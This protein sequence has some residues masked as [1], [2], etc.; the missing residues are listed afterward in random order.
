MALLQKVTLDDVKKTVANQKSETERLANARSLNPSPVYNKPTYDVE[1]NPVTQN[2]LQ[3]KLDT[4]DV[5][6][7]NAPTGVKPSVTGDNNTFNKEVIDESFGMQ[8]AK[9]QNGKLNEW[10]NRRDEAAGK[11]TENK[12]GNVKIS[13]DILNNKNADATVRNTVLA[14]NAKNDVDK[15][16]ESKRMGEMSNLGNAILIS[17]EDRIANDKAMF[18][19][20]I[21]KNFLKGNTTSSVNPEIVY[22]YNT[23]PEA[24][25]RELGDGNFKAVEA[26]ITGN[27][28]DVVNN[29]IA[30]NIDERGQWIWGAGNQYAGGVAKALSNKEMLRNGSTFNSVSEPVKQ[31]LT[32]GDEEWLKNNLSDSAYKAVMNEY[33]RYQKAG[34]PTELSKYLGEASEVLMDRGQRQIQGA[35]DAT[36][37]D[38]IVYNKLGSFSKELVDKIENNPEGLRKE[39]GDKVFESVLKEYN[40][41]KKDDAITLSEIEN[42][43]IDVGVS[44]EQMGLDAAFTA[45]TGVNGLVAMFLRASG[46]GQYEA[47]QNMLNRARGRAAWQAMES[48]EGPV[49]IQDVK[50]TKEQ[51]D[52][53]YLY[54]T[55]VGLVEVGTE[56]IGNFSSVLSKTYGK[57]LVDS[58]SKGQMEVLTQAFANKVAKS[59]MGK[60]FAYNIA[61]II[62]SFASEAVEE[63]IAGIADPLIAKAIYDPDAKVEWSEV[64]RDGL[65][66]GL[67]GALTGGA[68][69]VM[70][71]N[72]TKPYNNKATLQ[73]LV[74]VAKS[75]YKENTPAYQFAK[76]VEANINSEKGVT[77]AEV[78]DLIEIMGKNDNIDA[79]KNL[80]RTTGIDTSKLN[81]NDEIDNQILDFAVK[82]KVQQAFDESSEIYKKNLADVTDEEKA[83]IAKNA[84]IF[85]YAI[86]S[87]KIDAGIKPYLAS[88]ITSAQHYTS[89]TEDVNTQ[90]AGKQTG[91]TF[92]YRVTESDTL[93]A[94]AQGAD[95]IT[96]HDNGTVDY[97][98]TDNFDGS[99]YPTI[100]KIVTKDAKGNF[101]NT[102]PK[103]KRI[104]ND[105]STL[106][107]EDY[108]GFDV[109]AQKEAENYWKKGRERTGLSYDVTRMNDKTYFDNYMKAVKGKEEQEAKKAQE[110]QAREEEGVTNESSS[111]PEE[112]RDN[113]G[114]QEAGGRNE[115]EGIAE[116]GIKRISDL[117]ARYRVSDKSATRLK[118]VDTL[119][120]KV[121]S[122]NL[123]EVDASEFASDIGGAEGHKVIPLDEKTSKQFAKTTKKLNDLGFEN[124]KYFVGPLYVA[125]GDTVFDVNGA[126]SDDYKTVYIRADNLDYT[127]DQIAK[128]ESYHRIL[129]MSNGMLDAMWARLDQKKANEI[130]KKYKRLYNDNGANLSDRALKEEILCDAYGLMNMFATGKGAEIFQQSIVTNMQDVLNTINEI[131]SD[132][133]NNSVEQAEPE[134]PQSAEISTA[135]TTSEETAQEEITNQNV[136]SK[137]TNVDT[138]DDDDILKDAYD[139]YASVIKS[140]GEN[141]DGKFYL[142][143]SAI[144]DTPFNSN[145][146]D[147]DERW[148]TD[149]IDILSKLS[150]M[151]QYNIELV[152]DDVDE[153]TG[154]TLPPYVI[155]N[156]S[157]N[158]YSR[159]IEEGDVNDE[160]RGKSN[161]TQ[162]RENDGRTPILLRNNSKRA[163]GIVPEGDASRVGRNAGEDITRRDGRNVG[164]SPETIRTK[165]RIVEN[166]N[167]AIGNGDLESAQKYVEEY[168]ILNGYDTFAFNGSDSIFNSFDPQKT[169]GGRGLFYFSDSDK[170]SATYTRDKSNVRRYALD[171]GDNVKLLDVDGIV[172]TKG[173]ISTIDSNILNDDS[174]SGYV[175][176][177][178][179]DIGPS[180]KNYS[181]E[182]FEPHTDYITR[183]PNAI[184]SLD[185]E[186]FDDNGNRIPLS[187]RFNNDNDDIRY[188]R[189]I[190]EE[191]GN[192]EE[193][194]RETSERGVWTGRGR[195]GTDS[196][197]AK[198]GAEG[199]DNIRKD[200]II[201]LDDDIYDTLRKK[202]KRIATIERINESQYKNYE[203]AMIEA[204]K[205]DIFGWCVDVQTE[206]GLK[207][208]GAKVFTFDD[209]NAGIA[210]EPDG[211]I[212]GF[213]RNKANRALNGVSFT[214]MS[215]AINN[216]GI[217]CD[218]F[219]KDLVDIYAQFGMVPVART[220]FDF[221]FAMAE[222]DG[223][224]EFYNKFKDD[225]NFKGDLYP[226]IYFMMYNGKPLTENL[227]GK[228]PEWSNEALEALPTMDYDAAAEYRDSLIERGS[229]GKFSRNLSD[230]QENYFSESKIRDENGNLMPMYH[231][232]AR[233]DRVGY[234]FDPNRATSGPMAF[235]T[236]DRDI[237]EGYSKGKSDTSVKYDEQYRDYYSQFRVQR[238]GK[239]YSIPELW[240]VLSGKERAA[241]TEAAKHITFDD[242]AENIVY[243]KNASRGVG[244]FDSYLL[245]ENKGNALRA[246]VQSWL[247]NGN[248]FG[249]E[250]R[251][252]Q[253][254]ELAGINDATYMDP[255]AR[256]E[257]VYEVYLNVTKP[258]NTSTDVNDDFIK[259]FTEWYSKQDASTYDR[260]SYSAD[261]WD[262]NNVSAEKFIDRVNRDIEEETSHAW[263]S[264]PDSVTDYLK[265]LGYDG[266]VDTGGKGGGT[267]HTV[268]IPFYSNQ[269]KSVDNLNPTEANDIRYSR[270]ISEPN[271]TELKLENDYLK[272]QVKNIS[273]SERLNNIKSNDVAN[274]I[275]SMYG[276][277]YS[278][279]TISS[280]VDQIKS[281]VNDR[282]SSGSDIRY[283]D[284]K[285][286][287]MD[288]ARNV[289]WNSSALTDS[290]GFKGYSKLS[291]I[292]TNTKVSLPKNVSAKIANYE[293]WKTE[294]V[295][296]I[297]IASD[298]IPVQELYARLNSTFGDEMFPKSVKT[299][300]KQA[301]RIADVMQ[302][303]R[304]IFEDLY[305]RD[306]EIMSEYCANDIIN[307]FVEQ[308]A[309]TL[310]ETALT[311]LT[312]RISRRRENAL[313]QA[314]E[315]LRS[316]PESNTS[317][318]T[319]GTH[320]EVDEEGNEKEV[321]NKRSDKSA[322]TETNRTNENAK[323]LTPLE[324]IDKISHD[325]GVNITTGHV[326]GNGILGLFMK[327][328]K[329]IRIKF[330]NQIPEATHEL[331]HALDNRYSLLKNLPDSAKKELN[332]N[333]TEQMNRAKTS[334]RMSEGVA[335]YF[336]LYLMNKDYA[337][338]TYPELTKYIMNLVDAPTKISLSQLA[339]GVNAYYVESMK[340][341]K[342]SIRSRKDGIPD[343]RTPA[344]KLKDW[345]DG[346]YNAWVDAN[347]GILKYDRDMGTNV[348]TLAT[349][350]A[351]ADARAWAT[352][353]GD[354][355]DFDGNYT[356]TGLK[357]ALLG[358]NLED[359]V[360]YKDFNEYLV[361]SHGPEF[362]R[363]TGGSVFGNPIQDNAKW[364][365][366]RKAELESQ[367]S[368]FKDAAERLYDFQKRLL[369][370]YAV[371]TGL[372]SK[373]TFDQWAKRWNKYVPFNRV[374][375]TVGGGGNNSAKAGFAN[376]TS[377]FRSAKGSTLELYDPLDNI[378]TNIVKMVNAGVRNNVMQAITKSAEALEADARFIEKIDTPV[379]GSLVH[380][381]AIK[382]RLGRNAEEA[383][384]N[385][386]ENGDDIVDVVQAEI[387]ALDDVITQFTR[388]NGKSNEVAVMIDGK[389]Q[390]WKVNDPL[391]L[392]SITSLAPKKVEGILEA[393][394]MTSRMMTANIT[395][396]NFIWSITRNAPKDLIT[397]IN[398]S[399]VK[400]PIK[401]FSAIGNAYW[402]QIKDAGDFVTDPYY[403]EYVA[404]G[405]AKT[406]AYT[407]DIN[408]TQ[409][410]IEAMRGTE[411]SVIERLGHLIKHP[412]KASGKG[413][414]EFFA[415]PWE[416]ISSTGEGIFKD[417]ETLS[418]IIEV[419]PR[420]ATYKM[421]R[422]N[423]ASPQEA[424]YESNDVTVNFRRG[425]RLAR[426]TNKVV[427]FFNANVQG[428]DKFVRYYTAAD[429]TGAGKAKAVASR[430][431]FLVATSAVMASIVAGFN[432]R[433][434]D[435]KKQYERLSNFT[436]NNYWLIPL[437]KFGVAQKGKYLA[438]P[439]ARELGIVS[440]F[441]ERCMEYYLTDNK[442]AFDDFPTYTTNNLLP[443]GLAE[444]AEAAL[445]KDVTIVDALGGML[446]NLGIIG[447][448]S[449]L[450]SNKDF[451]GRDIVSSTYQKYLPEDQWKGSTSKVAY[452]LGQ[453]F[454]FSPIQ[455]DFI[456]EQVF[457]N[458]WKPMKAVM[459]M[460]NF[461]KDK[462]LD[463]K[464]SW[465][466]DNQYSNEI[467]NWIYDYVD[468]AEK[469]KNHKETPD[470]LYNYAMANNVKSFYST[471]YS[472]TKEMDE[473]VESR[474]YRNEML[475]MLEEFRDEIEGGTFAS[476]ELEAAVNLCK[477]YSDMSMLPAVMGKEIA[478][479][480]DS[481][482]KYPLN[483][484][485]YYEYQNRYN[486]YYYQL[487][488]Q[489]FD[490]AADEDE[491]VL[492]LLK[493]KDVAKELATNDIRKSMGI[494]ESNFNEKYA[495][496]TPADAVMYRTFL[497]EAGDDGSTKGYEYADSVYKLGLGREESYNAYKNL[498][499]SANDS[500]NPW[501]SK[502]ANVSP[503]LALEYIR[504][505]ST[506][507]AKST[508][509]VEERKAILRSMNCSNRD[510]Y[511]L[512]NATDTSKTGKN[513]EWKAYK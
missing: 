104:I 209:G 282:I 408:L 454:G 326:K 380:L 471:Y 161:S 169:R 116:R 460:D 91:S 403:A 409:N 85:K 179:I 80:Y 30:R 492:T 11:V 36:K 464:N 167:K 501:S 394:A 436:R 274:T 237:A 379:R 33:N 300:Y 248:I 386:F 132:N 444:L 126:V 21:N 371:D 374:V 103:T 508:I 58:M 389:P 41:A 410:A 345:Y 35:K 378:V 4:S 489:T 190:G 253:V 349:N 270:N 180:I 225:P 506:E 484:K 346:F 321:F 269:V 198:A 301:L 244:D 497:K 238:D 226:D 297:S 105:K 280:A 211:N 397:F 171:L 423:G 330:A 288:V 472:L 281:Y 23:N 45:L 222:I 98:F 114:G 320:V 462:S 255:D 196:A 357:A 368:E 499:S 276:S 160:E 421:L 476:K 481:K 466:K 28:D 62:P 439:K 197:D 125:E 242:D 53:A 188:S 284:L 453:A 150:S 512:Y 44:I 12:V 498:Y 354:M 26:T 292:V 296:N 419:G 418:N 404:M 461:Y 259:G 414:K 475:S 416:A 433:D 390:Y 78:L 312:E 325:F 267:S 412:I 191:N 505:C 496:M 262:K 130:L 233:T 298:G 230:A 182:V 25:R 162:G 502:Y 134:S 231:G 431:T 235:F 422:D 363:E 5:G 68:S 486:A 42:L 432:L 430:L 94:E 318:Y 37:D 257:G 290:E 57:G 393:Y 181:A 96:E 437:S 289:V 251:F 159:N 406:S 334:E 392:K 367:Y 72:A 20:F 232:T 511:Y 440:S 272:E 435:D 17:Q 332:S 173:G 146:A 151:G 450:Y 369:Q 401:M 34:E 246:L 66:G 9:N 16:Y 14:Y 141:V 366:S 143:V 158:K 252:L 254:L 204:R 365:D 113:L 155:F 128:H 220:K 166:Y 377:T 92:T 329:G 201:L 200:D 176:E 221:D 123:A 443:S 335:D 149:Q 97:I 27:H 407:A 467:G 178:V 375:P 479:V 73:S 6:A 313:N 93:P 260:D 442:Y 117:R 15:G 19:K 206:Q 372:I 279:E 82:A 124:V 90:R 212:V 434:D 249:E 236:N 425:G 219:G 347:N 353:V 278:Q 250:G 75:S 64:W 302:A 22:K 400:N 54:G 2:A 70:Q 424:F 194:L 215:T 214:A 438:L 364:M 310:G 417:I 101:R 67:V 50:L 210:V 193:G 185:V 216:G 420:F 457:G 119:L 402:N 245:R 175:C 76:G 452:H 87:D 48:G 3:G 29:D 83:T 385:K 309:Q 153:D 61:K 304:D 140:E 337:Q 184:K 223:Y 88:S 316:E 285:N 195:N 243:D 217:K 446:G 77:N 138:R 111:N 18:E 100:T 199:R 157:G 383:I 1:K 38:K 122:N 59:G 263:T 136:N 413:A 131:T 474:D 311:P 317:A 95:V 482:T 384:L 174:Y 426:E 376:Q 133:V 258:F 352:I 370:T 110:A 170:V 336:R 382:E 51:K 192:R 500:N 445:D 299:Q 396:N 164:K 121:Q 338:T 234:V 294:N 359:E 177:N 13:S 513:N 89:T 283:D 307:S 324:I 144:D 350:A 490:R 120:K 478:D 31:A 84:E 168:A 411:P 510:R 145:N 203:E 241:I 358:I 306:I 388:G 504:R 79:D 265:S 63:I 213:F 319:A 327:N 137:D 456:G 469:Q 415:H 303:Q 351:Y 40:N 315:A 305:S 468:M 333:P 373:D 256:N 264:I 480:D 56:H 74:D 477:E 239:D 99:Q 39:L 55:L 395:G 32:K 509:T 322:W 60:S 441:I 148:G 451:L 448:A 46:S 308:K 340:T 109:N 147:F 135:E 240:N 49:N 399:K 381:E 428:I 127:A 207:D 491:K 218:N 344:E 273:G 449:Y 473:T 107:G 356:G 360:E 331:G 470:T 339:D 172:K 485:Q 154:K 202:G 156:P 429:V 205:I 348:Y 108:T 391:L 152:E 24:L 81:T 295:D 291:N 268:V 507:K 183:N 227:N 271:K 69:A 208:S 459:P 52:K 465:I 139:H 361:V 293:M 447:I 247:E 229:E 186:T 261:L 165:E 455:I 129:A 71:N 277:K 266:I 112:R 342:P 328:N 286:M 458:V 488:G 341:A 106:V 355:F 387:D 47:E 142:D 187:E 398:F 118:Q 86:A 495:G 163:I 287:A 10:Y 189:N 487:V 7:G 427:P 102:T 8:L 65:V 494:K 323:V 362:M 483:Y 405:G 314:N 115:E 224:A 275:K 493:I 463:I 43:G 228:K 503:E 343:F